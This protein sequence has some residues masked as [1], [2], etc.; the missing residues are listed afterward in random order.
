MTTICTNFTKVSYARSPL[1]SFCICF[2]EQRVFA[3]DFDRFRWASVGFCTPDCSVRPRTCGTRVVG[4][5]TSDE[6]LDLTSIGNRTPI[7]RLPAH[8]MR[9]RLAQVRQKPIESR[10]RCREAAPDLC[11]VVFSFYPV[12]AIFYSLRHIVSSLDSIRDVTFFHI[13]VYQYLIIV[14]MKSML[15]HLIGFS[16]HTIKRMFT[17]Q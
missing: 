10:I 12:D 9:V 1:D 14:N 13:R 11:R 5:G 15:D 2:S 3:D 16:I 4:V 7:Q 8:S 17:S 6:M